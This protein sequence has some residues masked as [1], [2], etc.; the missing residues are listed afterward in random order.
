MSD[1][2]HQ[3]LKAIQAAGLTPPSEIIA[4]GKLHR[5]S[6]NG[7]RGKKDGWYILHSDGIPAGA[8]GCWRSGF[9]STWCGKS[10]RDMSAEER[11]ANRARIEAMKR[12]R[13]AELLRVQVETAS[14]AAAMWQVAQA[15]DESHG[16]IKRKGIQ[17]HGV[18]VN[19]DGW[20]LV[21]MRDTDGKLWNLERIAPVKP[22]EGN[23][24]KP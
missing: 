20:L 24:K 19:K 21:P 12:Q 4:D 18:K 1:Y 13:E 8:F 11:Q 5:F 15:A 22:E 16:Y 10:D 17:P 2:L 6:T 3:F 9:T 14:K 7:K 23:D